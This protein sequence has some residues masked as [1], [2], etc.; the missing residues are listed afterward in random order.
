LDNTLRKITLQNDPTFHP[1]GHT[2]LLSL[3]DFLFAVGIA[4]GAV[5]CCSFTKDAAELRS[6]PMTNP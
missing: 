2:A 5:G 4:H 1:A 3:D 6:K